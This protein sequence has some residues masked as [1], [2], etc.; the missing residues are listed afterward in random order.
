LRQP[1]LEARHI[2][3]AESAGNEMNDPVGRWK[4]DAVAF[5]EDLL[6]NPE[7]RKPFEM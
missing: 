1:Y 5:I 2:G 7:T 3:R 4:Q 6:R